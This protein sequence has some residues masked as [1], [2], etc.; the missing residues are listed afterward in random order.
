MMALGL[1]ILAVTALTVP[2]TSEAGMQRFQW[3][4]RPLLVF[5]PDGDDSAL[6]RQLEIAESHAAGWRERDMVTVV[7]AG[8]RPVTVDGTKA[9]DLANDTLRG[10]FGVTGNSFAAILVGK[11]GTEKLRRDAPISAAQLFRTIDAMP[12]RQR[13]MGEREGES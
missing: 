1:A 9:K 13:E 5:A 10:R 3:Q 7:V 6:A 12:M 8:D 2:S 11:D 4:N